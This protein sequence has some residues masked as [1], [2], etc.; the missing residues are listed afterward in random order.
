MIAKERMIETNYLLSDS[1]IY[2]GFKMRVTTSFYVQVY[3]TL[4]KNKYI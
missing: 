3:A 4:L 2:R 1:V